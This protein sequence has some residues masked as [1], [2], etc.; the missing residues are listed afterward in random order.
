MNKTLIFSG[1]TW[2]FRQSSRNSK[3]YCT[4]NTAGRLEMAGRQRLASVLAHEGVFDPAF[5][6]PNHDPLLNIENLKPD[7]TT[8]N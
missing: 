5:T 8:G 7:G 2:S 1:N 3:W 6:T 4:V